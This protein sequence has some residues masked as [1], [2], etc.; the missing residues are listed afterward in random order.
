M[1]GEAT[2]R[3]SCKPPLPSTITPLIFIRPRVLHACY[4]GGMFA[5]THHSYLAPLYHLVIA[6]PTPCH[7]QEPEVCSSPAPAP[8]T[9]PC[10]PSDLGPCSSSQLLSLLAHIR[11]Y[12]L[13]SAG[14]VGVDVWGWGVED[15]EELQ[16]QAEATVQRYKVSRPAGFRH[17]QT[18]PLACGC[19]TSLALAHG[20]LAN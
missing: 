19:P 13:G 18:L 10:L 7:G 15:R 17:H 5:V 4:S 1:K 8:R 16:Y 11:R 14:Y 3:L 6:G 20:I 9:T 12:P 2:E